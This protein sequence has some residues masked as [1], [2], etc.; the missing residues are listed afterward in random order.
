VAGLPNFPEILDMD[1]TSIPRV[2]ES[3]LLGSLHFLYYPTTSQLHRYSIVAQSFSRPPDAPAEPVFVGQVPHLLPVEI[4]GWVIDTLLKRY[5]CLWMARGRKTGCVKAWV[6]NRNDLEQL[7]EFTRCV[8]FDLNGIWY[9]SPSD[10]ELRATQ[11]MDLDEYCNRIKAGHEHIDPRLPKGSIVFE[12]VGHP[13][14][15][16]TPGAAG[17]GQLP[18]PNVVNQRRSEAGMGQPANYARQPSEFDQPRTNDF[19]Y[20]DEDDLAPAIPGVPTHS[21]GDVR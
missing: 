3:S 10:R 18:T 2:H 11:L 4:I 16:I 21:L 6:T 17:P 12:L 1:K 15:R 19:G 13:K 20:E 14:A 7:L 5:S 9:V 8:M